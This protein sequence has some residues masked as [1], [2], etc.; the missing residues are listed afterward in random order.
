M[1]YVS[2][3][4]FSGGRNIVVTGS[5]FDL[6]Q[7][8]VLKVQGDN[9]QAFEV[10]LSFVFSYPFIYTHFPRHLP[11]S[12]LIILLVIVIIS[13]SYLSFLRFC[14]L[15]FFFRVSTFPSVCPSF[16]RHRP[17]ISSQLMSPHHSCDSF[18]H[19][20]ACLHTNKFTHL[21]FPCSP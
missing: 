11:I 10:C 5:G 9:S 2:V 13:F 17:L 15:C 19:S 4:V 14:L 18:K 1:C 3:C 20:Q 8:A 21:H 7:T 6:V 16:Q 12:L